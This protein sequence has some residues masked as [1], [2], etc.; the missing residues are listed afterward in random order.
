MILPSQKIDLKWTSIAASNWCDGSITLTSSQCGHDVD[1]YMCRT[2]LQVWNTDI[3]TF[4]KLLHIKRDRPVPWIFWMTIPSSHPFESTHW[5]HTKHS[6]VSDLPSCEFMQTLCPQK[7][8]APHMRWFFL[9]FRICESL[10]LYEF[11]F[12]LW[13]LVLRC[14]FRCFISFHLRWTQK[15][16]FGIS[17]QIMAF[18]GM[19]KI[20]QR[21]ISFADWSSTWEVKTHIMSLASNHA[22]W[23]RMKQS[24]T[25]PQSFLLP[26]KVSHLFLS[27]VTSALLCHAQWR[28]VCY[29]GL[30]HPDLRQ[31]CE[32]SLT[33][34]GEK[35]HKWKSVPPKN[36]SSEANSWNKREAPRSYSMT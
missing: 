36:M 5:N 15:V 16:G 19:L 29:N 2:T 4:C 8:T 31:M 20:C 11:M 25:P 35:S 34:Q 3:L 27:G 17:L 13:H 26:P 10:N 24:G 32:L 12:N 33:W 23:K 1:L 28:L 21:R 18:C 14:R 30:P 7:S 9:I 22:L 6:T